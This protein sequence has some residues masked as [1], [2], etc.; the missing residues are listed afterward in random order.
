VRVTPTNFKDCYIIEPQ[1][2]NDDR[3]IFF[4]SFNKKKFKSETGIDLN[5]VQD[6][7]SISKKGVLRGLHFQKGEH[8]QAKW[9]HIIKGE[10]LDVVVDLREESSTFGQ[11]F[12]IR[13]SAENKKSIFIPK[14]MAHGFLTLT[15]EAIFAYKCDNY[16]HQES[17][18]GIMYND[19][20]L[21]IDWDFPLKDIILSSKDSELPSFKELFE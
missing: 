7:L 11:Y 1:I 6:N 20:T 21:D 10:V 16:Y 14:G 13:L 15:N 9:I 17:E 2:F 19:K 3:G 12:K 5:F 18:R 4:E 8:A